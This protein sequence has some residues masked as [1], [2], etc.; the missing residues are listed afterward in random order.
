ATEKKH[1]EQDHQLLHVVS[2]SFELGRPG[3]R[4]VRLC[5]KSPAR[6]VG[7]APTGK[8]PVMSDEHD[9]LRVDRERV[10]DKLDQGGDDRAVEAAGKISEAL[11][12]IER[13]R[14]HLYSFHQ[15]TGTADLQL[16]DAVDLLREAG[17]EELAA[18]VETE[19]LGRNV[20][21]G[22]WTFQIVE[23]YDDGYYSA[24]REAERLVRD[25]LAGG[26]RHVHEAR[27]KEDRR[28]R[29]R[30]HHEQAPDARD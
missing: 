2:S 18:R 25:R 12:T 17:Q 21:E 5:S 19:L 1:D 9:D 4:T 28:T 23:E 24:F 15:L 26:R 14:G 20:L 13:A 11:E 16:G 3:G 22:R 8:A 29:G 27:M 7:G 6:R 30:R 10:E